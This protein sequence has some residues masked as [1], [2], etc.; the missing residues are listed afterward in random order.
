MPLERFHKDQ[1][2]FSSTH[3][4]VSADTAAD[5]ADDF[6]AADTAADFVA[7]DTAADTVADFVEADFVAVRFVELVARDERMAQMKQRLH[8]SYSKPCRRTTLYC[9]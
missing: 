8:H 1:L 2:R 7:A 5:T 3:P 6:V 4:V 9:N